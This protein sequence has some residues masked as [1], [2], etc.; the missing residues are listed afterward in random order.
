[1]AR[2]R[3]S[4]TVAAERRYSDQPGTHAHRAA[5]SAKPDH[6]GTAIGSSCSS[7]SGLDADEP[8]VNGP[9]MRCEDRRGRPVAA[10]QDVGAE[11]RADG[12]RTPSS[13]WRRTRKPRR[14]R[15]SGRAGSAERDAAVIAAAGRPPGTS[16]GGCPRLRRRARAEQSAAILGTAE[17]LYVTVN[18]RR[19]ARGD[20]PV[21]PR[22]AAPA[23]HP[24][25]AACSSQWSVRDA[26][27]SA[28]RAMVRSSSSG[29][30]SRQPLIALDTEPTTTRKV[31]ANATEV[32]QVTELS[33]TQQS[34]ESAGRTKAASSSTSS[35][36]ARKSG[37]K[38][39]T[40]AL[41]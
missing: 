39:R 41:A 2:R 30:R 27:R 5:L 18:R 29:A 24:Q 34:I 14:A 3:R 33:S 1:M 17:L 19:S 12:V 7:P 16:G 4:R 31:H 20:A 40:M 26:G 36:L 11:P 10:R 37:S 32:E 38:C 23:D 22:A 35:T 9:R 6:R 13:R 15:P 8:R 28:R 21:K 25:P